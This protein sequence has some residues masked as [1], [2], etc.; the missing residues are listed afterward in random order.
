MDIPAKAATRSGYPSAFLI[1][2]STTGS[3][4]DTRNR[5]AP[6]FVPP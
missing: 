6:P 1:R 2:T 5:P 3:L 4:A